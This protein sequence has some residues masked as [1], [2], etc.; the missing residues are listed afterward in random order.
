MKCPNCAAEI[1]N[2]HF[3]EFCG[4]QVTIEMK[5]E[6]EQVNK[7]GCPRCGSSNTRFTREKQGKLKGRKEHRSYML[8]PGYA[9]IVV[10]HGS[11]KMDRR[12]GKHG[13]GCWV[14]YSS[15]QYR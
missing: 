15:F 3:C 1:G 14:G 9:M 12:K 2:N 7:A 8:R 6:Q 13:S 4:S 11:P 10:I 5:K